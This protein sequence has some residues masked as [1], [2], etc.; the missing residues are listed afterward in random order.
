MQHSFTFGPLHAGTG[1]NM[2]QRLNIA[3]EQ[4]QVEDTLALMLRS[5]L[6]SPTT[7]RMR[8]GENFTRRL[9]NASVTRWDRRTLRRRS[10]SGDWPRPVENFRA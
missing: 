10:C 2:V 3:Q 9:T 7:W 1:P 6:R 4:T 8:V 5:G